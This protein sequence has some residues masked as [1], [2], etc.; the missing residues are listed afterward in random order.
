[1]SLQILLLVVQLLMPV[2]FLLFFALVVLLSRDTL[3]QY[4][5][6]DAVGTLLLP[7]PDD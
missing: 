5:T 4:R 2:V 7:V 3:F 6:R 1:M